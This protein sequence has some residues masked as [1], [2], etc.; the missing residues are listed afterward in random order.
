MIQRDAIDV[1]THFIPPEFYEASDHPEW[2]AHV[3]D[4]DGT[5]WVVHEEGFAYP[6]DL[7]FLCAEEKFED[8]RMR[9]IDLSIVS[10]APTLFYYW[11]PV[12]DATAFARLSNDSLAKAVA[13]SG[14]KL[15]ALAS[16][17]MN[18]PEGSAR[19]LARAVEELG[20]VGAQIGTTVEGE[21]IDRDRFLPVWEAADHLHVPLVLHPYYV[22]PKAG[23]EDYYLTNIFV[24]PMDTTLAASRIIFSGLLD[25]FTNINL[26]LVHGG[27]FLPY[28]MGRLDHGWQVRREPKQKIAARPSDYLDRFYMD[29]I[30]H[31]DSALEWLIER[32]G[33]D[34]VVLGTDLPFDM[35]DDDPVGR[36]DRVT[37]G[38]TRTRIASTNAV[39]LFGLR[40][41]I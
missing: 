17:P 15:M 9:G 23:Y 3:E 10:L 35:G 5:P 36:L 20:M 31:N 37:K 21:Y 18:D 33:G 39:E 26:V 13:E 34:R 22:G 14:G 4:R 8:M 32:V 12:P 16:I 30:T 40:D 25:R 2:G 29:S 41:R 19:E 28:Q 1:H 24:N 7:T 6:F 11:I 38:E 27:G